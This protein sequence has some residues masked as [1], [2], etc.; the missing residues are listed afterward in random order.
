VAALTS[1]GVHVHQGPP[2]WN[3]EQT[4]Y[5]SPSLFS[6]NSPSRLLGRGWVEQLCSSFSYL[7]VSL[8]SIWL[9]L[10][11]WVVFTQINIF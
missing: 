11:F 6:H 5:R 2:A 10:L 8:V 7:R 1:F 9:L 4:C 3:H